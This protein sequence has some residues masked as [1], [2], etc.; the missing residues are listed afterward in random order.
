MIHGK[1][2][3][4]SKKHTRWGPFL[5]TALLLFSAPLILFGCSKKQPE[6]KPVPKITI[7]RVR[8]ASLNAPAKEPFNILLLGSDSRTASIEG[9]SDAIILIHIDPRGQSAYAISIPRDSRVTI[10]GHGKNKINAA[11]S[12]GGPKLAVKTI[13]NLG[14]IKIQYYAVT[15]FLGFANMIDRLG[16]VQITLE[17]SINDPWSGADLQAGSQKLTGNQALAFCR[18][19]HIPEGDFARAAHQQ[20]LIMAVFEQERT[21]QQPQD[22]LELITILMNDCEVNLTYREMFGLVRASINIQPDNIFRQVLPGNTATIGG[23][24][25]VI[26]DNDEMQNAFNKIR[27]PQ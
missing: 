6:K 10:P 4:Y 15:T 2:I 22:L 3:R 11:M 7:H 21:K 9:R 25:Y 16:G 14:N 20:D 19:R 23:T 5:L 26:L 18:S 27:T 8:E 1:H 17:K 12:Y 13:E 24:S